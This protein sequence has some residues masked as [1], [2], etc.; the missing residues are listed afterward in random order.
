M[1]D[2]DNWQEIYGSVKKH[3]LR[4]L[5][6]AFGVFWGILMLVLLLGAGKGLENGV[7]QMF[8]NSARNTIYI[9]PE[10]TGMPYKGLSPGRKIIFDNKD[11]EAIRSKVAEIGYLVPNLNVGD[12]INISYKDK[13]V[14]FALKGT[15]P[16][17]LAIKTMNFTS[18]RFI[19]MF[20]LNEQ[21]KVAVI[22]RRA[23][24]L[25][26]S[27]EDPIG[28]LINIKGV[29]FKVVGTFETEESGSQKED[30]ETVFVPVSTL[31]RTFGYDDHLTL[32]TLIPKPR[33]PAE[34][35]EMK[36]KQLL[37]ERHTIHPEDKE[38]ISSFNAEKE[39]NKFTS[40]FMGINLFIWVVGTGTI[41]AGIIGVG[42]IML[43][44]VK[45]RTREIGI[46]KALGATPMSI[47]SLII[48]ESVVITSLAGYVGLL[49]GMAIV[50]SVSRFLDRE[51]IKSDFFKDPHIDMQVAFTAV[52]ILVVTGVLAGLV[53]ARNA[54]RINPIE[55]LKTE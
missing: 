28:K 49:T 41:I 19:N 5:L 2:I 33:I 37:T 48:M 36:V 6:T 46:R 52:G 7:L 15:H 54:A 34:T 44:I 17:L 43:I 45:E 1:F 9:W 35:V 8:S 40:L 47:I 22:G 18:G 39:F 21:R 12:K 13:N 51:G 24:E 26:F 23:K 16:D 10:M 38:A 25:F 55:A 42:N 14:A 32:F 4:T 50:E 20:D 11:E 31:Q 53:P 30:A 3:K 29:Y 27:N